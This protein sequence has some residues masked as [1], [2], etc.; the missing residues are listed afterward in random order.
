MKWH[1][2]SLS[3]LL[4]IVPMIT[5]AAIVPSCGPNGCQVCDLV[6][7][8]QNVINYFVYLA[9]ALAT[10]M[11]SFAG[12][13]YATSAT[14]PGQIEE[15]HKIF[16]NV[17]LGMVFVLGAWLIV[18]TIM[19]AFYDKKFGPW[20]TILCS[21]GSQISQP[22]PSGTGTQISQPP[23]SGTG[24]QVSQNQGVSGPVSIDTIGIN[25]EPIS[26]GFATPQ[27]DGSLTAGYQSVADK[28]AFLVQD[29]C[30]SYGSSIP[31]CTRVATAVIAAESSGNPNAGCGVTA[32]CGL[33]QVQQPNAVSGCT[34]TD[35][36]CNINSGVKYLNTQ[37]GKFNN[38]PNALAAYNSGPTG[39]PGQSPSGLNSAMVVSRDCEGY[40]AW[41][42]SK[43][44]G[45]LTETQNYVSNICR[46]MVLKGGKC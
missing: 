26:I 9:V 35:P 20:N 15:A 28:Y 4:F 42:C 36:A 30:G 25:G 11:F 5:M 3:L 41:Q 18:D 27:S 2:A 24:S 45:G 40:Y 29:A 16:W 8:A 14:N 46:T 23:P 44:P 21:G 12:I 13:K 19:G 32:S 43:N 34:L 1:F 22:P 37:Y 10:I 39:T 7:L 31:D 33:M 6:Q 17:L 38:V